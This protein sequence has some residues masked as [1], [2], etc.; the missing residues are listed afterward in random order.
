MLGRDRVYVV[1]ADVFFADPAG[2]FER[3][4]SWLGL[5]EWRPEKVEQWNA[6]PRTP[7]RPELRDRL[8][9]YFEPY[10]A[11]LAEQMGRAPSWRTD[12]ESA[13]G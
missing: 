8:E 12:Q 6:Q 9:R 2:E 1:D 13:Q 4:R 10:D 5:P 3:L 11:R 7:M